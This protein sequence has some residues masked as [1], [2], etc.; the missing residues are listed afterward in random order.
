[1]L[2]PPVTDNIYVRKYPIRQCPI[3]PEV[4]IRG[5]GPGGQAVAKTNNCVQI[6]HMPTGIVV[7][8]ENRQKAREKLV[9]QLDILYNK[10]N[11]FDAISKREKAEKIKKNESRAKKTQ[12]LKKEFKL[13][14]VVEHFIVN[15]DL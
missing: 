10:D 1:M 5:S 4:F 13:R 12:D 7:R 14:E 9:Y 3:W 2:L 11:S 8:S 6:K 15:E